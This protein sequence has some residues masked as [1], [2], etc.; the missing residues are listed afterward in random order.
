MIAQAGMLNSLELL[1]EGINLC[2][3]SAALVELA[4]APQNMDVAVALAK[5]SDALAGAHAELG[6]AL[7]EAVYGDLKQLGG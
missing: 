7:D 5:F 1:H 4:T 2:R 6:L 3:G